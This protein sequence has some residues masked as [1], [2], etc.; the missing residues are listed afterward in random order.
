MGVFMV[1]NACNRY[2]DSVY[3]YMDSIYN[4]IVDPE[5]QIESYINKFTEQVEHGE[6]G[7]LDKATETL[8]EAM[9]ETKQDYKV[10]L[11]K[12]WSR[13]TELSA[14]NRFQRGCWYEDL[15]WSFDV[16]EYDKDARGALFANGIREYN[17]AMHQTTDRELWKEAENHLMRCYFGLLLLERDDER[18][19]KDVQASFTQLTDFFYDYYCH[20]DDLSIEERQLG[21]NIHRKF[22]VIANKLHLQK[23]ENE[24]IFHAK[25][26]EA[27]YLWL[28]SLLKEETC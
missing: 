2:M 7:E 20:N 26:F 15:A 10:F 8:R 5:T 1:F 28:Q 11:E 23:F 27:A 18:N 22:F 13:S 9:N 14:E 3:N 25:T 16:I 19:S 4:R 21:E 12:H 6:H 17:I 24:D